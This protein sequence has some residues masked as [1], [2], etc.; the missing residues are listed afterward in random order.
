MQQVIPMKRK[1]LNSLARGTGLE[2]A[3]KRLYNV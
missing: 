3:D 1:T 2:T